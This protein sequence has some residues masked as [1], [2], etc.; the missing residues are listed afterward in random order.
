MPEGTQTM[1]YIHHD[2]LP[3]GRRATYARCVASERPQ[4]T[5]VKRVRLTA[6]GNLVNYPGKV[7]TPTDETSTTK[8]LFNSIISTKNGGIQIWEYMRIHI[9]TILESI[10]VQYKLLDLVHNGYVLVG[11]MKWMHRL[12]QS[13][14]LA[15]VQLV[16]HLTKHGY[17]PCPHTPCLWKRATCDVTF[18]LVVDDFGVKYTDKAY[19]THLINAIWDIYEVTTYCNGYL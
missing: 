11:I 13:G 9:S 8:M 5:E 1:W 4:K 7:N 19:D 17:E 12:P 15:Y 18:C 2:Q 16:A 6:G 3:P 10:I 14:I